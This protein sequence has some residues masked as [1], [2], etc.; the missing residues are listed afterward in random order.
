MHASDFSIFSPRPYKYVSDLPIILLRVAN[1]C[2][3]LQPFCSF[4]HLF[5]TC[6][7]V[8]IHLLPGCSLFVFF[9]FF[10][11]LHVLCLYATLWI[12]TGLSVPTEYTW[13][14]LVSCPLSSHFCIVSPRVV[15]GFWPSPSYVSPARSIL[16]SHFNP[17]SF[18][19]S[20]LLLRSTLGIPAKAPCPFH[21]L[22]VLLILFSS[23]GP[24]S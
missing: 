15:R 20:L 17:L 12:M 23:Y 4:W 16:R 11:F 22:A 7:D 9:F 18:A 3:T 21:L 24:P 10:P 19:L 1:P 5:T 6:G 8:S 13:S 14:S 2:C